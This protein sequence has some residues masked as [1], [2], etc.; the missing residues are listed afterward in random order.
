LVTCKVKSLVRESAA[1][2]LS[3]I[4]QR[5]VQR[6]ARR[7]QPLCEDVDRHAVERDRHEHFALV[8]AE[9]IVDRVAQ[10]AEQLAFGD[11]LVRR[12]RA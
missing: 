1:Q 2:L 8:C 11:V 12:Q 7:V 10:R 6:A 5:L 4:V 3:C 9:R